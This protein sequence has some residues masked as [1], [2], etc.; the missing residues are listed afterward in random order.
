MPVVDLAGSY[1]LSVTD[2]TSFVKFQIPLLLLVTVSQT[3]MVAPEEL[4]CTAT[5][6]I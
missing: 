6:V 5:E 2:T 4:N 3:L 1:I